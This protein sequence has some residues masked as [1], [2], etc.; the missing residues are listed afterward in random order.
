MTLEEKLR[1]AACYGLVPLRETWLAFTPDERREIGEELKD[2]L[3]LE[4][5]ALEVLVQH[6]RGAF[7]GASVVSVRLR[8]AEMTRDEAELDADEA[9]YTPLEVSDPFAEE[10]A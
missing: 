3:K 1:T 10:A 7:P 6:C 5:G 2:K 4:A 8:A 9:G